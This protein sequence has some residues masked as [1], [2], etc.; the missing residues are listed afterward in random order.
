M[1]HPDYEGK[2]LFV[3]LAKMVFDKLGKE[4]YQ[5]VYTFP[6]Q[7]SHG[8]FIS[9]LN[10]ID[11]GTIPMLQCDLNNL[12]KFKFD[13]PTFDIKNISEIF[14]SPKIFK[15]DKICV[16]LSASYLKWRFSKE[17]G[18]SYKFIRYGAE[19]E[20]SSLIIFK[21]YGNK[22]IDLVH[23]VGEP[24]SLVVLIKNLIFYGVKHKISVISTWCNIHSALH[25]QLERLGFAPVGGV[26]YFS[27]LDITKNDFVS[28][29]QNW[30]INMSLSDIF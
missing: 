3:N 10:F 26:T 25:T 29:L 22:A 11:I 21:Q 20:A 28:S 23:M 7:K 17:S 27:A 30:D 9:K 4:G 6:N 8:I 13:G 5:F 12:M 2:G 14:I 19:S 24:E 18:N 15:S 16:D 1:T